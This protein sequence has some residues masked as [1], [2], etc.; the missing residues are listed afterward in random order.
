MSNDGAWL[1]GV[2]DVG[3]VRKREEKPMGVETQPLF[4]K[5]EKKKIFVPY[6]VT[7]KAKEC[8]LWVWQQ[9]GVVVILKF[10]K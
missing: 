6:T 10:I 4:R 9:Y 2:M 3:G 7:Q 8:L 1:H 5:M